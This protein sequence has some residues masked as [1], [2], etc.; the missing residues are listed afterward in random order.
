MVHVREGKFHFILIDFDLAI[1]LPQSHDAESSYV[2]SSKF[3]TGTLPFMAHELVFD[4]SLFDIRAKDVTSVP[5]QHCLRH[6]YESLF[7]VS[8][9]SVLSLLQKGLSTARR[10]KLVLELASWSTLR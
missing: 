2:A 5:I 6:D 10:Q 4:A 9:Y 1:V 7:W 8:L 3:R